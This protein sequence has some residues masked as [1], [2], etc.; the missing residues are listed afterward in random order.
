MA[1]APKI[2]KGMASGSTIKDSSTLPRRSPTVR[3]A[4]IAP[5]QLKV[6]VPNPRLNI[7]TGKAATG[8][9]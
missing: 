2:N 5:N 6:S 8:I 9:S 4:P 1:F 7:M 3:P